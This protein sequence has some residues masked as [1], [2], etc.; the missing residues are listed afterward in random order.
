MLLAFSLTHSGCD[1][2]DRAY[3]CDQIC[4]KYKECAD[5]NYDDAACGSRCR[6]EAAE[7]EA[8]EDKADACQA[9]ID[10]RSCTG[11]VFN[12]ADECVGIV[13]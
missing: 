12:C 8:Y 13:P 6:D 3:D 2:A 10:E 4:D 1:A 5:A 9:C 11:A 7:S